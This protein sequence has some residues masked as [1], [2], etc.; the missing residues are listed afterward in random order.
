MDK[1]GDNLELQT[2]LNGKEEEQI[3]EEEQAKNPSAVNGKSFLKGIT[4]RDV[5]V[6]CLER[7]RGHNSL[8]MI[9]V[10]LFYFYI[11][12]TDIDRPI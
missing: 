8:I 4:L 1:N 9:C 12:S 3:N 2:L 6:Q 11:F 10:A 7:R 5:F